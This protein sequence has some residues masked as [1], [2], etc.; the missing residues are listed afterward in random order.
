MA[1]ALNRLALLTIT[2][3]FCTQIGRAKIVLCRYN[4][5]AVQDSVSG[6][7]SLFVI[8]YNVWKVMAMLMGYQAAFLQQT[9]EMFSAS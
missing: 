9:D 2:Q 3:Q 4:E 1:M 7:G 6:Y 5:A 8:K